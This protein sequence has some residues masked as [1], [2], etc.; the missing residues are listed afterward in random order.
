[1]DE[2][3]SESP[4]IDVNT[5]LQAS[6]DFGNDLALDIASP[7]RSDLGENLSVPKSK[8]KT[9]TV[10]KRFAFIFQYP[11]QDTPYMA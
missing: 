8:R 2:E 9:K 10:T 7:A 1:M 5:P 3:L 6:L 4:T 11:Y